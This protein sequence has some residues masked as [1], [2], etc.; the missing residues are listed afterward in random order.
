MSSCS[1]TSQEGAERHIQYAEPP[2]IYS[3]VHCTRGLV[4]KKW[5][6]LNYSWVLNMSDWFLSA[7][8]QFTLLDGKNVERLHRIPVQ[9]PCKK[10]FA[11]K[12]PENVFHLDHCHYKVHNVPGVFLS[13]NNKIR[14][15][16]KGK[17]KERKE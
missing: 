5:L 4:P 14:F 16:R 9:V 2:A 3:L 12:G 15:I 8:K 10:C 6:S 17:K 1:Q 13:N 11:I 7:K